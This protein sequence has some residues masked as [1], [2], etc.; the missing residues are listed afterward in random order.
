MQKIGD[1]PNT[2]ADIH[3]EF[4]DG[5]VAGGVPPTILPAEWFNTL[6]RELMSVLSAADI[7]AD[8]DQFNQVAAAIS[9]LISNGIE[10]SDFLQAANH[11]KEIKNAGATAVAETL[12]N[13]GLGE[14]AKKGIATNAEMQVGTADKLVSLVGLMSLFGKRTFTA[15]DYIRIPDVPG[16][17]IIQ[18]GLIPNLLP[19]VSSVSVWNWVLPIPFPSTILGGTVTASAT[20]TPLSSGANLSAIP[21][22]SGPIPNITGSV[23]NTRT[24][25]SV[26]I[27]YIAIGY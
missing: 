27:Y 7:E 4:T 10:G 9:K 19:Y 22:T 21:R 13:L 6:Q 12:A 5:N 24:D 23:Q 3:G 20:A 14:A 25:Q 18:W 26:S 15:N 8:S 2:R 11:L 1:I 16:G 17:L